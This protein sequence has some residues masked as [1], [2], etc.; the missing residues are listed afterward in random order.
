[1]GVYEL[2]HE[3]A[4]TSFLITRTRTNTDI[5]FCDKTLVPMVY[6]DSNKARPIAPL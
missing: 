1:L 4:S 3:C 6:F 2:K 5:L